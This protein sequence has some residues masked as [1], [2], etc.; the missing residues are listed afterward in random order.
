L[1][2]I[3]VA[4]ILAA[5][6]AFGMTLKWPGSQVLRAVLFTGAAAR[7]SCSDSRADRVLPAAGLGAGERPD[8]RA[9]PP[10]GPTGLLT[11]DGLLAGRLDVVTDALHHLILRPS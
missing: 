4:L 2:G 9:N 6:L 8:Q 11:V 7:C 10:T 1:Y 5:L 3:A